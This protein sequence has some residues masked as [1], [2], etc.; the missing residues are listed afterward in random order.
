M[1]YPMEPKSRWGKTV[2]PFSPPIVDSVLFDEDGYKIYKKG[3][4]VQGGSAHNVGT[5]VHTTSGRV[6]N[7]EHILNFCLSFCDLFLN[8]HTQMLTNTQTQ[9]FV[10]E[11]FSNNFREIFHF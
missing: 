8:T 5:V 2:N 4:S 10:K 1:F 7:K 3:C 9:I 6:H 11:I